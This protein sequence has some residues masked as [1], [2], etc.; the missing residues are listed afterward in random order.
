MKNRQCNLRLSEAPLIRLQDCADSNGVTVSEYVR[1]KL[2]GVVRRQLQQD[3]RTTSACI[4]YVSRCEA[5]S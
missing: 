3:K 4:T 5:S 2:S 1:T